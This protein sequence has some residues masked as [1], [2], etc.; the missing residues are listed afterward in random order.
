M[1]KRF[2]LMVEVSKGDIQSGRDVAEV[3][4][5]MVVLLR[6]GVHG[7]FKGYIHDQNGKPVGSFCL[8]EDV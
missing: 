1:A 2:S 3:L 7:Q 5:R 4:D 8:E 6:D